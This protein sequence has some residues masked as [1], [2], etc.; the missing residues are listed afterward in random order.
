MYNSCSNNLPG[1]VKFIKFQ[2]FPN[3]W[4]SI[5]DNK[6]IGYTK[7]VLISLEF[8][9]KILVLI[10]NI[11]IF[12]QLILS[13]TQFLSLQIFADKLEVQMNIDTKMV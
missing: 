9:L 11:F 10:N 5:F 6:N 3:T 7:S 12:N 2:I 13:L 8:L 1:I 4:V